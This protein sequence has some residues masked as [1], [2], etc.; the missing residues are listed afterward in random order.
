M[1]NPKPTEWAKSQAVHGISIILTNSFGLRTNSDL[2]WTGPS[3]DVPYIKALIKEQ[4]KIIKSL[5]ADEIFDL[6]R[7]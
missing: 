3:R 4:N 7:I 1:Q 6:T 2:P 5:G